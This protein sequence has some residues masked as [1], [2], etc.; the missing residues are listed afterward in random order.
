VRLL[1]S[2]LKQEQQAAQRSRL[3]LNLRAAALLLALLVGL[4]ALRRYQ[5]TRQQLTRQ[6]DE[7]LQTL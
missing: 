4:E 7:Q 3:I 1:R 6:Q 2:W 5:S